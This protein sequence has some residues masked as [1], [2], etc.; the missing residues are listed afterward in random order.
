[1]PQVCDSVAELGARRNE[2]NVPGAGES[3]AGALG[4]VQR[5]YAS[6]RNA[7]VVS[8]SASGSPRVT[9]VVSTQSNRMAHTHHGRRPSS[10]SVPVGMKIMGAR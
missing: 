1:M 3:G 10:R 8:A 9:S 5:W 7:T 6:I 2:A 4:A